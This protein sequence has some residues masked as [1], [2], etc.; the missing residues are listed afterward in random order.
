ML[1]NE[2]DLI[3]SYLWWRLGSIPSVRIAV[4]PPVV[5]PVGCDSLGCQSDVV[6]CPSARPVGVAWLTA[7]WQQE[8]QTPRRVITHILYK[9]KDIFLIHYWYCRVFFHQVNDDTFQTGME[10][11]ELEAVT[12]EDWLKLDKE[13]SKSLIISRISLVPELC[14]SWIENKSAP[15]C[16]SPLFFNPLEKKGISMDIEDPLQLHFPAY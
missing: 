12:M 15:S 6:R 11:F 1:S 5:V 4:S 7:D 13:S 3:T 10:Y 2:L 16:P 14:R 9:Q 8:C